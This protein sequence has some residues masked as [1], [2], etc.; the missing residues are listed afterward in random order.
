[1]NDLNEI[2]HRFLLGVLLMCVI[3]LLSG[4][5]SWGTGQPDVK[6][7]GPGQTAVSAYATIDKT[8]IAIKYAAMGK[9][10]SKAE[11]QRVKNDADATRA[12]L[13]AAQ[14]AL[15]LGDLT[16]TLAKLQLAQTLLATL[17]AFLAANP[18]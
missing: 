10:V 12:T 3:A 17:S 9:K 18:I 14:A 11:L 7:S 16:T 2:R 1:M 15:N 5:A 8:Y 6:P 13:D 4:C